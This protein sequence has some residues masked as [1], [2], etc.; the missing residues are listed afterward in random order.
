MD[1]TF[2]EARVNLSKTTNDLLDIMD[3]WPVTEEPFSL[4]KLVPSLALSLYL[5]LPNVSTF[6]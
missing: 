3:N 5:Y 6:C 1:L 4:C 2:I